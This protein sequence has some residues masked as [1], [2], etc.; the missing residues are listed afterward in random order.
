[1]S[2]AGYWLS[3]GYDLVISELL[4]DYCLVIIWLVE[5]WFLVGTGR[6]EVTFDPC[7]SAQSSQQNSVPDYTAALAEYY[8]QQPYLWNPAQI[9]VRQEAAAGPA[10]M[11]STGVC[12]SPG[13][14]EAPPHHC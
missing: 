13:S 3:A 6:F 11:S 1:M 7:V 4:H 8:R 14:L 9:Q 10:G 5:A 2:L 12:V